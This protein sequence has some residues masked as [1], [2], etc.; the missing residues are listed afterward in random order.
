MYTPSIWVYIACQRA[1]IALLSNTALALTSPSSF[2]LLR[3][4]FSALLLIAVMEFAAV[5]FFFEAIK[6]IFVSYVVSYM[7]LLCQQIMHV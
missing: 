5:V 4:H 7:T 2:S 1:C 6:H 3:T